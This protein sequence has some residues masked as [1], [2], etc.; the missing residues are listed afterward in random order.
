MAGK[1]FIFVNGDETDY[2]YE[3]IKIINRYHGVRRREKNGHVDYM[4]QIHLRGQ[5]VVG[6]YPSENEAA[7]AYNKAAAYLW[8]QKVDREFPLNYISE[9]EKEE[10]QRI[11]EGIRIGKK[12]LNKCATEYRNEVNG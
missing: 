4:T 6:Y 5:I 2:R 9:M 12:H 7:I 3:N 10:Y 11:Y 8:E 1:D